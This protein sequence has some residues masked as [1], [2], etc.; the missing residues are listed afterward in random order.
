MGALSRTSPHPP[1]RIRRG[2]F[3]SEGHNAGDIVVQREAPSD[4]TPLPGWRQVVEVNR[5]ASSMVVEKEDIAQVGRAIYGR[6]RF[7]LEV[8]H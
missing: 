8:G 1:G 7:Q 3:E 2:K 4:G 5:R 6:L